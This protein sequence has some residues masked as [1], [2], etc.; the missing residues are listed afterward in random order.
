MRKAMRGSRTA[1]LDVL[2]VAAY[3]GGAGNRA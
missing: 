2:S 1:P 3:A